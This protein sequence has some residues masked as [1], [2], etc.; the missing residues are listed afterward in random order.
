M[1]AA[2]CGDPELDVLDT[3]A[4]ALVQSMFP[5]NS[6]R[7]VQPR[8]LRLRHEAGTAHGGRQRA[9]FARQAEVLADIALS[10][11]SVDL[12]I[13]KEGKTI[14]M[15]EC[16][17][18]VRRE[19]AMFPCMASS[20]E[21]DRPFLL[22]DAPAGQGSDADRLPPVQ[23]DVRV[24]LRPRCSIHRRVPDGPRQTGANTIAGCLRSSP[25]M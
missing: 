6:G 5:S 17:P 8:H 7:D 15:T 12:P 10:S 24:P 20:L 13:V 22:L 19:A 1:D 3:P 2:F 4:M 16:A 11:G 23:E 14:G 25:G 18:L 9:A 21:A